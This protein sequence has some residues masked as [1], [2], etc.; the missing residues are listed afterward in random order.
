[1]TIERGTGNLL[2]ADVD[3]LVNTVNTDGVMGKGLALQ[4]KK[5]FPENFSAYERACKS[6]ELRTGEMHVVQRLTSPRFIINFPTKKHWR[7]PSRIEYIRDGLRALIG[8]VKRLGIESIAVPPLGCGNGGLDWADVRPLILEAFAAVPEVRVVLF[9]PADAPSPE[10]IIDRRAKPAMTPSRAA[11]LALMGRYAET[12][13]DYRL[14]LVEVQKLTYFLQL[15]GEDLRLEYRA[16]HYGPYADNLRKTLRNIEGHYTRGL[17]DG[18]NSPETPLE[19]LPGAVEDARRFLETRADVLARLDRVSALIEGFETP[20]GMEL[21]G[22]VHWVMQHDANPEDV[23]DVIAKVHAWSERKRSQMKD[24]H[25]RA[26]WSRLRE[27]GW[28]MA[29]ER[30]A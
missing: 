3:A 25:I 29:A 6:G 5:A 19:V 10:E 21:L 12:E 14:S 28:T 22:S 9:A 2:A 1:M 30:C 26:A 18:K 13:Y 23:N 20:F 16:H 11:V 7:H 8:E 17:G 4:F 24:G 15:A 27:H